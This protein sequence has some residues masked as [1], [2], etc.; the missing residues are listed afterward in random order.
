MEIPARSGK[1]GQPDEMVPGN[2]PVKEGHVREN[3]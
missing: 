2:R 1:R 3:G